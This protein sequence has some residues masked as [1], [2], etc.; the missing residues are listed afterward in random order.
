MT[1]APGGM[2]G[3]PQGGIYP[4][5]AMPGSGGVFG[6]I[7]GGANMP[8]I[9]M[10]AGAALQ[11]FG[12]IGSANALVT[13]AKRQQ[14]AAAFNA[15]QLRV[16]AGQVQAASQRDAFFANEEADLLMSK[17]LA[18]AGASGTAVNSPGILS[19]Q[20]QIAERQAYRQAAILYGGKDKARTMEMQA[21]SGL[22]QADLAMADAK[23]GRRAGL[24]SAGATLLKGGASLYRY[25]PQ[26][27]FP[28]LGGGQGIGVDMGGETPGIYSE[29]MDF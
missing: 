24:F 4:G 1:F 12:Q 27:K 7:F 29:E 14:Q 15:E 17:L 21:K 5:V 26:D 11:A 16:N 20:A 25:W 10:A 19:L 22:Y 2:P 18:R 9:A 23:A 13:R 6:G 8:A 28:G 3:A